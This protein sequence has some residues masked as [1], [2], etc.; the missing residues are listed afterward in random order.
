M[1]TYTNTGNNVVGVDF[2]YTHR[3]ILIKASTHQTQPK[4]IVGE[5][6]YGKKYP[7]A[8]EQINKKTICNTHQNQY[9]DV[10]KYREDFVLVLYLVIIY[11]LFFT[12]KSLTFVV[13]CRMIHHH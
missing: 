6:T 13:R 11:R 1:S 10:P 7:M 2:C 9:F 12:N 5:F 8:P 4:K 3:L